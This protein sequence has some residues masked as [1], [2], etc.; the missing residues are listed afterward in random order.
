MPTTTKQSRANLVDAGTQSLE[1]LQKKIDES[2][3]DLNE[4]EPRYRR[5]VHKPEVEPF[6]YFLYEEKKLARGGKLGEVLDL[7]TPRNDQKDENK[8][9]WFD[10]DA[11]YSSLRNLKIARELQNE[12]ISVKFRA[13]TNRIE[14]QSSDRWQVKQ[15][16]DKRNIALVKKSHNHIYRA[17]DMRPKEQPTP[18]KLKLEDKKEEVDPE[19]RLNELREKRRQIEKLEQELKA[20]R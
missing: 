13:N 1:K 7:K 3:V 6:R 16:F 11:N 8:Q 2:R 20:Q 18:T 5:P 15:T 17:I 14:M 10:L 4:A 12:E 19:E 9:T